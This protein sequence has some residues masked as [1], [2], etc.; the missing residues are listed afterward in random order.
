MK[1]HLTLEEISK[2]KADKSIRDKLKA[3]IEEKGEK[4]RPVACAVEG[5]GGPINIR[6]ATEDAIRHY[7]NSIGDVNPLYRS[8]DYAQKSIYGGLIAPPHFICAVSYLTN[9]AVAPLNKNLDFFLGLYEAGIQV[10]WFKP[11]REND[12]FT[13]FELFTEAIDLTREHR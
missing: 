3:E 6:V 10:E 5:G 9:I 1:R 12:S 2:A 4:G 8:R 7:C 11:I 13:A